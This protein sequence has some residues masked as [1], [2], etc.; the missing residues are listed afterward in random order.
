MNN[1]D[2]TKL[3]NIIPSLNREYNCDTDFTEV[4]SIDCDRS[5]LYKIYSD[6]AEKLV[7]N[8]KQFTKDI[9][10][11][12]KLK[13]YQGFNDLIAYLY[14]IFN[15]D[16]II[17]K[18]IIDFHF[19][20][21]LSNKIEFESV[22]NVLTDTI[23]HIDS[24]ISNTLLDITSTQPYYALSWIITWFS[25]N[26]TDVKHQYRIIEYLLNSQPV[27]IFYISALV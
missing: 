11:N 23:A 8:V 4:I 20:P 2:K 27:T 13:Y 14:L 6:D 25:H 22:L 26:N 5:I 24:T 10:K 21:F 12:S 19:Y 18:K 15:D 17:I 9:V 3:M 7:S 1:I 16:H